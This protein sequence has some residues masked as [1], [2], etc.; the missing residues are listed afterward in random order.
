MFGMYNPRNGSPYRASNQD[1]KPEQATQLKQRG[2]MEGFWVIVVAVLLGLIPAAIARK[3]GRSFGAWWAYGTLMFIVALPVVL[4]MKSN[5]ESNEMKKCPHCAEFIK[6]DA[7]VCR[8]CGRDVLP[9]INIGI[10]KTNNLSGSIIFA[11][12]AVLIITALN[13]YPR[14]LYTGFLTTGSN[15]KDPLEIILTNQ[16]SASCTGEQYVIRGGGFGGFSEIC[17]SYTSDYN[18]AVGIAGYVPTM[19][20]RYE[21]IGGFKNL[22]DRWE[23]MFRKSIDSLFR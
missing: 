10:K 16:N 1:N 4:L 8:Y 22:I 7:S 15:D 19:K 13:S 23:L 6:V 18:V 11:I 17:W 21:A 2:N 14:D 3:K 5:K 9:S 12:I 20:G